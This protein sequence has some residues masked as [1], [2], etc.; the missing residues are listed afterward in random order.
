M[1]GFSS[2][3]SGLRRLSRLTQPMALLPNTSHCLMFG[4]ST[5][6]AGRDIFLIR[7][8]LRHG[9]V[10]R[11]MRPS[12][13]GNLSNGFENLPVKS[14]QVLQRG[15]DS[16]MAC[17]VLFSTLTGKT[18]VQSGKYRGIFHTITLKSIFPVCKSWPWP[19]LVGAYRNVA[20]ISQ[21]AY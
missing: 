4:C 14:V 15:Y 1:R 13:P 12:N 11:P 18:K 19:S 17:I 5:F 9:V 6:N 10:L 16:S 8:V 7:N 20:E 2:Q 21:L 3:I